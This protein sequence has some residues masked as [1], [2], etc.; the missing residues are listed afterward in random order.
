MKKMNNQDSE[1][2]R[3]KLR[4]LLGRIADEWLRMSQALRHG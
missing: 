4:D 3:R 2:A 1:W